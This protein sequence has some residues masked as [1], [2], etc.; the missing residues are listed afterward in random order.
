MP[1]P[2]GYIRVLVMSK[3]PGQNVGQILLDLSEEERNIIRNQ[4]VSVLE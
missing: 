3:V 1:Y 4:L 2:G